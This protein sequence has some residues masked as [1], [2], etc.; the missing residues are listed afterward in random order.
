MNKENLIADDLEK[1]HA[2]HHLQTNT[3][4]LEKGLESLRQTLHNVIAIKDA[5]QYIENLDYAAITRLSD[6]LYE[7]LKTALTII[8]RMLGKGE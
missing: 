5:P 7:E 2:L 3:T 4:E 6:K 1:A 8:N